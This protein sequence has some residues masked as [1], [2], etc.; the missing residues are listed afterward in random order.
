MT[1]A[2]RR[3][4]ALR[5]FIETFGEERGVLMWESYCGKSDLFDED[6]VANVELKRGDSDGG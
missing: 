5:Y 6:A 1:P 3:E 2:D 4:K